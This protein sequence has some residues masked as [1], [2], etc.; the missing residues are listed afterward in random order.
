MSILVLG[1][2]DF[3]KS[4]KSISHS[5]SSEEMTPFSILFNISALECLVK[6]D[7]LILW[8]LKGYRWSFRQP[9]E[10]VVCNSHKKGRTQAPHRLD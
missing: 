1:L 2:M 4:S 3:S 10:L 6:E 8:V 7:L 5:S 9:F